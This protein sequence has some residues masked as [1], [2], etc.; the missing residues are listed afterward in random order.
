M[1]YDVSG[2]YSSLVSS[3]TGS[4]PSATSYASSLTSENDYN[5]KLKLLSEALGSSSTSNSSGNSSGDLL[6]GLLIGMMSGGNSSSSILG[7]DSSTSGTSS[8]SNNGFNM[9]MSCLLNALSE[10]ERQTQ[11]GL[12]QNSKNASTNTISEISDVIVRALGGISNAKSASSI[13]A[14][15]SDLERIENAVTAASKK[16]GVSSDLIRA[17]IKTESNYNS[18][19]VSSAG[20]KGLMQLMPYNLASYGVSDPFNIEENIHAGTKHIKSYLENYGYDVNMALAAYNYGPGNMASRGISS[21]SDF[22]KLPTET[23]NYLEKING[24]I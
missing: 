1:S 14:S 24:L 15:G 11:Q 8:T 21:S 18:N 2:I 13:S 3:M 17:I 22:Y 12:D 6:T 10:K 4:T 5:E 20:A 16:Y 19:A 23:K 7:S 9:M